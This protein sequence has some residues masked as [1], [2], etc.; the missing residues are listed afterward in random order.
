[1]TEKERVAIFNMKRRII[2]AECALAY[3]V[4]DRIMGKDVDLRLAIFHLMEH[5]PERLPR[6]VDWNAVAEEIKTAGN[7]RGEP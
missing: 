3:L 4:A 5:C 2:S 6:I 1:M 7:L